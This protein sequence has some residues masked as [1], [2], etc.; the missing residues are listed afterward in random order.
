MKP[1]ARL[2]MLA[3]LAGPAM[4]QEIDCA[5]AEA[6]MELTFCAE[7]DWMAA[8]AEL[9]DAYK[10]AMAVL[11]RVDASVGTKEATG[12]LRQAQ[13]DWIAFRDN[14]CAAE[15]YLMHG[16]S[17]EPMLIYGCRARLTE[18]RTLDLYYITEMDAGG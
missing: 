15:A 5:V 7:Q 2:L 9:N 11:K 12:F 14:A 10:A 3:V 16:G 8:D 17:A 13:R 4:A 1:I 6:Q 18:Q